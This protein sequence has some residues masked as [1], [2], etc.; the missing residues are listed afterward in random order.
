M[1][2]TLARFLFNID[3]MSVYERV[4]TG[5]LA[6]VTPYVYYWK[7]DAAP[8]NDYYGPFDSIHACTLHHE[9]YGKTS[10]ILAQQ[11]A[12]SSQPEDSNVIYVDFKAR[13]RIPKGPKPSPALG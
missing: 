9:Q 4:N 3:G 12:A 8:A 6:S 5:L 1:N 13:K 7:Y 11:A 10:K 2:T